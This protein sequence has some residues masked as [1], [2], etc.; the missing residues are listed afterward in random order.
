MAD[1]AYQESLKQAGLGKDQA[2][3]YEALVKM[4]PSPAS[5]IAFSAGIG[6]PL[7]YKVLDELIEIGL[8]EKKEEPKKVARFIPA[9]PL[10]LKEVVEKRLALA[11]GAQTALDGVLGK[12]TSDFNLQSGKPGVQF[13]EGREGV[14][15]LLWDSL[16]T[17]GEIYTYADE[18]VERYAAKENEEYVRAR[19]KK[20]I[21][22]KILMPDTAATRRELLARPL[23]L[24]EIRLLR[25]TDAPLFNA[26][27]E[28]YENTVS[29]LTFSEQSITGTLMRDPTIYRLHKYLFETAWRSALSADDI[30]RQGAAPLV[31]PAS[32]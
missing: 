13:F 30:K 14:L 22:K 15:E 7:A 31:P 25:S 6:R 21:S 28:I 2:A 1:L 29:H 24:T 27:I 10:K 23:P 32:Q 16:N 8:V 20:G 3:I 11:Q 12:L 9:H 18:T 19:I 26:V 5:D 4:G 17:K